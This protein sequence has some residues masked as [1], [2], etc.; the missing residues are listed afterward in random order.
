MCVGD[1]ASDKIGCCLPAD[2]P[3]AFLLYNPFL[4]SAYKIEATVKYLAKIMDFVNVVLMDSLIS[5][6]P[7]N[8]INLRNSRI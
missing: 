7:E 8:M 2:P 5:I 3:G 4:K 1:N 6:C